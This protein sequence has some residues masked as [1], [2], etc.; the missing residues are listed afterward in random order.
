[1]WTYR[2]PEVDG[3]SQVLSPEPQCA[4]LACS[5]GCAGLPRGRSAL[6]S[7]KRCYFNTAWVCFFCNSLPGSSLSDGPMHSRTELPF[8]S[9]RAL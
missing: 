2:S 4:T 8:L 5:Q 3:R 6:I 7:A 1:V 9:G